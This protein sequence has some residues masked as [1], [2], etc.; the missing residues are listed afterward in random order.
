MIA[1]ISYVHGGSLWAGLSGLGSDLSGRY[2]HEI[3]ND[4]ADVQTYHVNFCACTCA[5][6]HKTDLPIN[7]NKR[8]ACYFMDV[9]SSTPMRRDSSA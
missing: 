9:I 2:M 5:H 1:S 8:H 7:I 4:D 3:V 6:M